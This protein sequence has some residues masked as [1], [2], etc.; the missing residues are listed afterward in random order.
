MAILRSGHARPVWIAGSLAIVSLVVAVAAAWHRSGVALA[1]ASVAGTF[2]SLWWLWHFRRPGRSGVN[3]APAKPIHRVRERRLAAQLRDVRNAVHALPDAIVLV[4][5]ND[6]LRWFNTAAESLLG[7][8]QSS[9]QGALL[10][11]R[12]SGTDLGLWLRD[13][14]PESAIDLPAPAD[15]TLRINVMII[16]FNGRQRLLIARDISTVAR[17]EQVRRDFVANVSHE[18]RTPLTVIHGYLELLE[19]ED[20]PE[21]GPV[22]S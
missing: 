16:P 14:A 3:T 7:L 10:T 6:R 21:L 13:R 12:L 9:D 5:E 4:D 19:P 17:L 1:L 15:P 11:E 22:L 20:V 2:A 8:H 18:L